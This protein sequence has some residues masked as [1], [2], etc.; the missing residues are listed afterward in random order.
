MIQDSLG[1]L[2]GRRRE[3]NY[4]WKFLNGNK[5]ENYL[6]MDMFGIRKELLNTSTAPCSIDTEVSNLDESVCQHTL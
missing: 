6:I 3:T 4:S 2:F 1:G 5:T